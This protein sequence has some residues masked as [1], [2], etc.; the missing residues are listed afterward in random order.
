MRRGPLEGYGKGSTTP[1]EEMAVPLISLDVTPGRA[2]TLEDT[3]VSRITACA[4]RT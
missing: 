3:R 4:I 2:A 1:K